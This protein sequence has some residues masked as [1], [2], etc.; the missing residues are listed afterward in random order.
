MDTNDSRS[1]KYAAARA[2]QLE[3][4]RARFYVD[5]GG[6]DTI[7]LGYTPI[8]QTGRGRWQTRDNLEADLAQ[9][10]ISLTPAQDKA[11][12][13]IASERSNQDGADPAKLSR[14]REALKSITLTAEQQEKLFA[15]AYR[16]AESHARERLGA[17]VFGALDPR[18]RAELALA[19]YQSPRAL[20]DAAPDLARHIKS[21]D[22]HA[23]AGRL[24]KMGDALGDPARYRGAAAIFRDPELKGGAMIAR[25]DTLS[26][27][28]Q[29]TGHTVAE[30]LTANPQITDPD[31]IR[32][33]DVLRL[34]ARKQPSAKP[35]PE[36][37]SMRTPRPSARPAPEPQ[38]S[39][40]AKAALE[41]MN[42][43]GASPAEIMSKP[44]SGITKPEITALIGHPDY[45]NSVRQRL[46]PAPQSMPDFAQGWFARAYDHPPG[47]APWVPRASSPARMADGRALS[48]G[49]AQVAG[50]IGQGIRETAARVDLTQPVKALQTAL[51]GIAGDGFAGP[52]KVDGVLGPKTNDRIRDVLTYQGT[53]PLLGRLNALGGKF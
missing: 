21:G 25:G 43:L 47:A 15:V 8:V 5:R 40:A 42:A 6:T 17:D 18:R 31:R 24:A 11:L 22:F 39:P 35:D 29:R 10:G 34:P 53:A 4:A 51:N 38:P 30:I 16:R 20:R 46:R 28:A 3:G 9:A 13:I 37:H 23:A 45:W 41:R 26:G 1:L 36:D 52:L 7:G 48:Q 12:K 49:L 32:A 50:V 2:R 33:G 19:A 14:A 44:L 27:I